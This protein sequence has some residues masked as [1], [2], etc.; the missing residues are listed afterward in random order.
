[1]T[2]SGPVCTRCRPRP[3]FVCGICGRTGRCTIS[4][5][6]GQPMCDRCRERWAVCSRCG[7]G[8]SLK[9]GTLD[10]PLCARCVNPDPAFW[11]RCGVCG[12][13]WQLTTA[14]CARCSLDRKLGLIP[15]PVT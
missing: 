3:E 2:E 15:I 11:T 10:A 4:R 13:T 12:V 8:A 5:A 1:M 7:D 6:T 14:E 9:G